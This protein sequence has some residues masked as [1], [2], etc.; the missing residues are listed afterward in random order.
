MLGLLNAGTGC[1][2]KTKYTALPDEAP[3]KRT[4]ASFVHCV[5]AATSSCVEPNQVR[6]GWDAL[7]LLTWLSDG[8]P[9]AILDS[10]PR[11]LAA[12]QDP[13]MVERRFVD[14]IERYATAIRGAECDPSDMQELGPLIDKA[15]QAAANRLDTL[16]MRGGGLEQVIEGLAEEAHKHLDGGHLVQMDCQSEPY[17]LYVATVQ[18]EGRYE[19]VG[20]TTL[21]AQRYGGTPPGSEV[22]DE[23]LESRSLGF[24]TAQAPIIEG[25]VHPYLPFHV[26]VF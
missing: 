26:E 19:V 14:E 6:G 13:R 8:S 10:L 20:L 5:E 4:A 16:G 17:R 7:Y 23:R 22:V 3:A 21:L 12:H 11:E 18:D 1:S 15:A 9:V 25:S 24:S 2:G